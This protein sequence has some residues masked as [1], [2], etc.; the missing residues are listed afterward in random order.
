MWARSRQAATGSM[1]ASGGQR[2]LPLLVPILANTWPL[3][4]ISPHPPLSWRVLELW[5]ATPATAAVFY[6]V[7]ETMPGG[8]PIWGICRARDRDALRGARR[9]VHHRRACDPGWGKQRPCCI[10]SMGRMS[11]RC[12]PVPTS[13]CTRRSGGGRTTRCIRPRKTPTRPS[14]LPLSAARARPSPAGCCSCLGHSLNPRGVAEGVEDEVTGS[15]W[16]TWAAT[17]GRAV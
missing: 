10:P 13:L 14:G 2:L 3:P 4:P 16:P 12:C 1:N 8:G 5:D 17:S 11:T 15:C 9:A 6:D 7:E